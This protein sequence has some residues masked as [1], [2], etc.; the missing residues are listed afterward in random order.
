MKILAISDVELG[1]LYSSSVKDRFRDVDMIISCGD[2]RYS[3]LEYLISMLNVPLYFVLGNHANQI[4][5]TVAGPK[6]SPDGGININLRSVC[7]NQVILAGME[8]C[9]QYNYGPFQ[10]SQK[11]MWLRAFSLTPSMFMNRIRYGRYL[12]IF[13]THAPP[14]QIHDQ[15]DRPHQGIKA[16]RWFIKVFKPVFHLHGHIHVYRNSTIVETLVD[17][18]IVTNVFGYKVIQINPARVAP[19]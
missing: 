19:S 1:L 8:G 17:S 13:V 16:F 3:Y 2:L 12:D 18:T 14:W 6:R 10:Y 4:E 15:D 9:V 7:Y 5:E 11:E